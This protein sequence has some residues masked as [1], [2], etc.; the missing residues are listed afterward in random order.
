MTLNIKP[1]RSEL[2]KL[3]KQI[4]LAKSGHSLLKKKR[5]GMI[6]EFFE[7]L[8][9]A[10]SVRS[11]LAA[12]YKEA[13]K[14][15]NISRTLYTDLKLRSLAFAIQDTPEIDVETKNIMGVRVP[16]IESKR[17]VKTLEQRKLGIAGSTAVIDDT[18]KIYEELVEGIIRVAEIETAIKR[19]LAEI[20]KTKRR[21]NAL[22]FSLIPQMESIKKFIKLRLEE[23]EREN[24]FRL[25]RVKAKT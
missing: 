13:Q 5:D 14:K 2:I 11:E 16:K 4:K 24:I 20:E 8:K 21:V 12:K 22:E 9:S 10:K 17:I 18:I 19:L 3:N 6:L 25:K 15:L 7:I 1:T 23:M